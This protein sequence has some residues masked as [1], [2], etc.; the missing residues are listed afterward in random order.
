MVN[1]FYPIKDATLYET[2]LDS[3]T[4]M[5][6]ILELLHEKKG[7][8]YYNSRI[9]LKFDQ[10]EI[11]DF[12]ST[13][14]VQSPSYS[15][16]LYVAKIEESPIE[17]SIE[18]RPVSGAW[19]NGTGN[20]NDNVPVKNGT[21]WKW[22]DFSGSIEWV[23]T[24][25]IPA[26]YA[27]NAV[28]GGGTWYTESNYRITS[29]IAN[30][31]NDLN[32][33]VSQIFNAYSSS[34]INNDGLIIKFT[35]GSELSN[36][37]YYSYKFF[38]NE[39]NTIYSPKLKIIWDD[40]SYQTGSLSPIDTNKEFIIYSRIKE[41]YNQNEKTKIRLFSRPKFLERTYATESRYL[42]NYRLPSSSYY[43]I[44][45]TVTD[46]I[47]IPFD[48]VGTKISCDS[49]SNYFNIFMDNFQ[50]ERFYKILVKVKVDEFEQYILDDN[51]Y[52]KVVR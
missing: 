44:R 33:N 41:V 37:G 49:T 47:I 32:I 36:Y 39:S 25:S 9:L 3:N 2:K 35:S 6:S 48:D 7:N 11:N 24:G 10:S 28:T 8:L 12:L 22:R 18:T 13:Y 16:N 34:I 38:S 42:I 4:G 50:P 20:A 26:S 30:I 45:D 46:D 43:E 21:S 14:N 29:S 23:T 52:F 15:L 5:D 31:K 51:I 17:V 27:Y 1:I 19:E 40:S